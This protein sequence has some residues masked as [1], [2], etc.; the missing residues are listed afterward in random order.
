MG[1]PHVLCAVSEMGQISFAMAGVVALYPMV[2][3]ACPRHGASQRHCPSLVHAP[4]NEQSR[5][6]VQLCNGNVDSWPCSPRSSGRG[7]FMIDGASVAQATTPTCS[8]NSLRFIPLGYAR[9]AGWRIKPR[10]SIKKGALSRP[11]TPLAATPAVGSTAGTRTS[12]P[13]SSRWHEPPGT[14]CLG[15]A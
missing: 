10:Q 9:R 8:R 1:P 2:P 11:T 6:E 12:S 7:F 5:L 15:P 13:S 14:P 4:F 3:H